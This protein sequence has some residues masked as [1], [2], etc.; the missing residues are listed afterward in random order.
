MNCG[1]VQRDTRHLSLPLQTSGSSALHRVIQMCVFVC[2]FVCVSLSLQNCTGAF[3]I[4]VTHSHTHV[5]SHTRTVS[6]A[7]THTH[8]IG[9]CI[10]SCHRL[11]TQSNEKRL[12]SPV[13]ISL[14]FLQTDFLCFY[15]DLMVLK[16]I[17]NAQ[18]LLVHI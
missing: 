9:L 4:S 8:R 18:R 17:V 13:L 3:I 15:S 12:H 1:V 7:R 11:E 2:V 14:L 6:R 16:D 5:Q 10:C